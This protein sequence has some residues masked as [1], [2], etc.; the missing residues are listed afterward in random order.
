MKE[1]TLKEI[2]EYSLK[3]L[4]HVHEFCVAHDIPYT[5]AYGTLIGAARHKGFIPWDDDVDIIMTR[6][7]F[8]RFVRDYESSEDFLLVAPHDRK[9]YVAFARVCDRKDTL[10]ACRTPWSAY[11]T[12]VW[13]DIFP[14]D[15]IDDD[16]QRH[17]KRYEKI[18]KEWAALAVPRGAKSSF[19]SEWGIGGNLK[20]LIKKLMSFNGFGLRRKVEKY[21]N[22]I[23]DKSFA[24]SSHCA[25]LACCDEYGFYERIDFEEY[26]TLE[27][28]GYQLM[29]IEKYDKILRLLYGDYMQLPPEKSR[30]PKQSVSTHF[31]KR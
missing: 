2:Q 16:E 26:T 1:M 20:I 23:Q 14:L 22:E 17:K 10:A 7:N 13:V 9:S 30:K 21:I 18:H 29:A 25:Q 3:V 27:F 28:E 8:E 12:G 15:A 5:L 19:S 6:E 4:L 24:D 31:F 11:S